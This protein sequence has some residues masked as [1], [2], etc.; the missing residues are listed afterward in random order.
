MLVKLENPAIFSKAIDLISELVTE[1]RLKVTE[2]GMTITAMDPANVSMVGFKLPKSAFSEFQS[3]YEVL[4]INLDDLKKILKRCKAGSSLI[5]NK[6][7]NVLEIKIVDK[8]LRNFTLG[9][10]EIESEDIDFTEKVSRMEFSSK[11]EIVSQELIDSIDDCAVVA[12][13]CSFVIENNTFIIKAKGMNS[14]QSEFSGD[15][16]KIEAEN[17]T[18][19]YSLEYLQKFMK[20]SKLAEKT[21]LQFANDHPLRVDINTNQLGLSFILAPRVETED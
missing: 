7:E 3:D 14:A 13:S 8:I 5:L 6:K 15:E 2:F 1:V 18:A 12:D 4:G 11:V 20:A 19:K 10:I 21:T 16:A 9:L 17:C